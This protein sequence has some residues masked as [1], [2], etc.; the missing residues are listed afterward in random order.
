[1]TNLCKYEKSVYCS[2]GCV[3]VCVCLSVAI[4]SCVSFIELGS[5]LYFANLVKYAVGGVRGG[6]SGGLLAWGSIGPFT[7]KIAKAV[8]FFHGNF[9]TYTTFNSPRDMLT[10]VVYQYDLIHFGNVKKSQWI[11]SF[12]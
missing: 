9:S 2:M 8:F 7:A 12:W 11:C 4:P 6:Q 1:M 5:F 10:L 3:C